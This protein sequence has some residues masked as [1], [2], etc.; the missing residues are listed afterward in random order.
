MSPVEMECRREMWRAVMAHG[1][2]WLGGTPSYYEML[3]AWNADPAN[4][5][6]KAELE[7][8]YICAMHRDPRLD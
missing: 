5:E 4:A 8:N 7:R 2:P 3:T 1:W 6:R